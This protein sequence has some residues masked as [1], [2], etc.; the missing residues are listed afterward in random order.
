MTRVSRP[1]TFRGAV[2]AVLAIA[3]TIAAFLVTPAVAAS[4]RAVDK[5]AVLRFGVP[6][7]ENGGVSFDPATERIGGNPTRRLWMDLIYD[8]M[9]RQT[10]DGKGAPG[11]ATKWT[12]PDAN[13]VQLTLR[14]GA[15]FSDGTPFTAAA[16]KAA[17]DRLIA[18]NQP[19]KT[20]EIQSMQSIEAPDDKTVVVHLSK[21]LAKT[22][23]E[24][25]L[26][27]SN[28]LG[29]PAPSSVANIERSPVG[30]GPMKLKSYAS[31]KLS[32][33]KNPSY[34]DPASQKLAGI[35]FDNVTQG[36]PAISALQAGTV[37][38]IWSIPPDSIQTLENAGFKVDSTPSERSYSLNLCG[39]QGPFTSKEA[40]QAIQYAIDR[41]AINQGA[42]AGT[43]APAVSPIAPT[44]E[45]YDKATA[46]M[47]KHSTAK[48]KSLL[49]Q[50]GVAPGTTIKALVPA[51]APYDAIGE[52]VQGQLKDVGVDMQI[53]KTTD[54]VS[55]ANRLKPDL[56]PVSIDPSLF[57]L[58]FSGTPGPLNPC[59]YKNDT[60]TSA[61]TATQDASKSATEVQAAYDQLQKA[62]LDDSPVVVTNLQGL[63]AAHTANVKGVEVIN[64]PYGPQLNDVYM[65]K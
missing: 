57:S 58:V 6:I 11:L 56:M 61:L 18:A 8:Q 7:E 60:I 25:T 44:S 43:G 36:Q 33:E 34:W 31:G 27:N 9:I 17:W 62:V 59:G 53:T 1:R 38:L 42:L 10:P 3:L 20:D 26:K 50:A 13:T 51:Q 22:W 40:R 65:T 5:A 4:R 16:V 28:F 29:V 54:F 41:N 35:D 55:D 49:K 63:L 39:T 30:A 24:D 21:P 37:D 19:N 48:A 47:Y 12:T 23:V 64:S 45:F 52:V 32:V 15:K 2:G 46:K 14:D